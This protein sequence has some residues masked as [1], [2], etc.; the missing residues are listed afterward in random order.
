[1]QFDLQQAW[2][3]IWREEKKD[4]L[5]PA[6]PI[7][8]LDDKGTILSA[9]ALSIWMDLSITKKQKNISKIFVIDNHSLWSQQIMTKSLP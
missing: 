9:S 5:Y 3:K 8:N 1:M 2:T 4:R 7:I 6:I